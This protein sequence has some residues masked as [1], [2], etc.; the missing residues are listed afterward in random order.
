MSRITMS[1]A[2]FSRARAAMR[3]ACS[4]EVRVCCVLGSLLFLQCSPCSRTVEPALRDQPRNGGRDEPLQRLSGCDAGADV[5][6]GGRIRLDLEEEDAFGPVELL[7]HVV[8]LAAR[9]A[10]PSG[11]RDPSQ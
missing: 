2:S 1:S 5:P 9:K 8:Q 6:G 11:H 10:G 4:R 3:R 7:E